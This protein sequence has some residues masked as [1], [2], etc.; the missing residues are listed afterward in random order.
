MDSLSR[1]RIYSVLFLFWRFKS[2]SAMLLSNLITIRMKSMLLLKYKISGFDTSFSILAQ[3]CS[4]WICAILI[5]KYATANNMHAI[6]YYISKKPSLSAIILENK[7]KNNKPHNM[8]KMQIFCLYF[9]TIYLE[10]SNEVDWRDR[11]VFVSLNIPK[12]L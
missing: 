2:A 7:R 4:V 10:K 3:T 6:F 12:F 9:R 1:H 8:L 11:I 5:I